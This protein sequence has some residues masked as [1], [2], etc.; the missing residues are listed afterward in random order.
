MKEC[1]LFNRK[2]NKKIHCNKLF[3]IN[4]FK[5]HAFLDVQQLMFINFTDNFVLISDFKVFAFITNHII[6][7]T[8]S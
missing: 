1:N 6:N 5:I 8:T 4:F 7:P 3:L 2:K